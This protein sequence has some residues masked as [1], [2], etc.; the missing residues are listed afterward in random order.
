[1][2]ANKKSIK[3]GGEETDRS[4]FNFNDFEVLKAAKVFE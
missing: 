4:A 3:M 1:M 2:V